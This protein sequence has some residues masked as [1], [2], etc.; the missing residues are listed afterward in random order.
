MP[1]QFGKAANRWTR[2]GG[3]CCANEV[4]Q[5]AAIS[6]VIVILD[7]MRGGL[8]ECFA[9]RA[10]AG[11]V[12]TAIRAVFCGMDDQRNPVSLLQGAGS[13]AHTI[14]RLRRV[15]LHAPLH[16]A[17]R[18]WDE[19]LQKAMRIGPLKLAYRA[20]QRYVPRSI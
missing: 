5:N 4:A 11:H 14:D 18:G 9:I 15:H 17:S 13:P 8:F 1:V 10:G 3:F 19:Y 16:R 20:V 7:A 6:T 2:S 12:T